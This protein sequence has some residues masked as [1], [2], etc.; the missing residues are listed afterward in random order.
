[1]RYS[2]TYGMLLTPPP[3]VPP[4]RKVENETLYCVVSWYRAGVPLCLGLYKESNMHND[5]VIRLSRVDLKGEMN[6]IFEAFP[7]FLSPISK[8]YTWLLHKFCFNVNLAHYEF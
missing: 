5:T 4:Y 1:M 7:N 6:A 2:P 8:P 3:R